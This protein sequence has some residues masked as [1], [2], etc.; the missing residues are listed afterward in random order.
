MKVSYNDPVEA[1]KKRGP[2]RGDLTSE[3]GVKYWLIEE[4]CCVSIVDRIE[5][6]KKTEVVDTISV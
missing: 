1:N 2:D 4:H 5:K 3:I 6:E